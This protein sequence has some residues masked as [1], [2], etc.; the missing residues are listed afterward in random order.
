M[1]A[2][3]ASPEQPITVHLYYSPVCPLSDTGASSVPVMYM[4]L[5]LRVAGQYRHIIDSVS[6]ISGSVD[7][8]P[9]LVDS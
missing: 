3:T 7:N 8:S 2:R 6:V 1:A 4:T 9:R 5:L